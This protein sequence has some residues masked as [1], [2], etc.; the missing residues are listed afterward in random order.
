MLKTKKGR[1]I[2]FSIVLLTAVVAIILVT[3]LLPEPALSQAKTNFDDAISLYNRDDHLENDQITD[4][5]LYYVTGIEA[6]ENLSSKNTTTLN[7]YN[8]VNTALM[9]VL[10]GFISQNLAYTYRSDSYNTEVNNL[11]NALSTARQAYEDFYSYCDEFIK[12]LFDTTLSQTDQNSYA[13]KF[14]E[15]YKLITEANI[16]VFKYA[17]EIIYNSTTRGIEVNAYSATFVYRATQTAEKVK[18]DMTALVFYNNT[19]FIYKSALTTF[20]FTQ[21]NVDAINASFDLIKEVEA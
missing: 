12:P 14:L 10:S 7:N 21:D 17:G 2:F 15:K 1:I 13:E 9:E 5:T 8:R 19:I 20:I 16:D 11:N 18:E 6:F 3:V 4:N